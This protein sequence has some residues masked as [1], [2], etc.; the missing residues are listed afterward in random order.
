MLT[1]RLPGLEE[2]SPIRVVLDAALRTPASARLVL[3]ARDAPSL[4]IAAEGASRAAEARLAA[5]GVEILRVHA[6]A[7]GFLDLDAVMRLLAS[8]GITLVMCEGGPRLANELARH[9]LIDEAVVIT[10]AKRLT[11]S[12]VPALGPA[13]AGAISKSHLVPAEC[14]TFGEDRWARYERASACSPAS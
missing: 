5:S 13:L 7:N 6:D 4:I 11:G 9:N 3:S 10:A 8:R 12:G 1:C 14:L 2:R